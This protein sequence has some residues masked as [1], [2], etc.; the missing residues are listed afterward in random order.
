MNKIT[1]LLESLTDHL[2]QLPAT[3]VMEA[4]NPCLLDMQEA[5]K[6]IEHDAHCYA[7]TV[8]Q[9][10]DVQSVKPLWTYEQCE[11]WLEENEKHLAS[12]MSEAGHG[13]ISNL[14]PTNVYSDFELNDGGCI[15]YPDD[16]GTIRR[17]D[18]YGNCEEIRRPGDDDYDEWKDLFDDFEL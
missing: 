9:P 16:D 4:D 8:F 14:A 1:E 11:A 7:R 12:A 18:Q 5:R 10:E 3:D 6:A 13:V 2:E 17:I 15:K